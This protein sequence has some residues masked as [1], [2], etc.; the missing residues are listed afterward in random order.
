MRA[1]HL[2][3]PEALETFLRSFEE[4]TLAKSEWTHGAHVAAAASYL[5]DSNFE[6]VL[7]LMRARIRAFNVAVGGANTA[8][9]GYH[10]TLTRFWLL[11][12]ADSLRQ[13]PPTSRLDAARHAV[14][15]FG[16]ARALHTLY[17]SGDVV[18]DSAARREWRPPDLL[19]LPVDQV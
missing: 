14:Q 17:Y 5:F 16:E 2:A 4:G 11:I 8:T 15:V 3:T 1:E 12:V 10:E 9:S 6:R 7:P 18:K 13:H 19:P